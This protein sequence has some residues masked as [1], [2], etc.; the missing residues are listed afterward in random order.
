MTGPF[1][2]PGLD[3]ASLD[4]LLGEGANLVHWAQH[5]PSARDREE[6]QK[7]LDEL[8][9]RIARYAPSRAPKLPVLPDLF[10]KDSDDAMESA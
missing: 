9:E 2:D 4:T 5:G 10:H 3:L 8:L 7:R 6:A 1:S